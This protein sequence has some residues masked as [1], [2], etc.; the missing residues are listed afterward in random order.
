MDRAMLHVN[1]WYIGRQWVSFIH[2]FLALMAYLGAA[3]LIWQ[4]SRGLALAGF[5][6][7]LLW[8]FTELLG[9]SVL[10]FAVNNT[11]RRAY[12]QADEEMRT[13]LQQNID[14]VMQ[15][16][17]ALFFLLLVFFLLGT[18]FYGLGTW[19]GKGLEKMISILFLLG[20]PLTVF[21]TISGYTQVVWPGM[22]AGAIYPVLQ[23]VSR[24][25]LGLW[26]WSSGGSDKEFNQKKAFSE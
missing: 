26:I 19:R 25:L 20:V 22:I 23:P 11:W 16:W 1:L 17:D 15:W 7:F 4:R 21:I 10:I 24:G 3:I 13:T 9:V 12:P 8:G 6:W 14:L 18:L 5:M 2:I